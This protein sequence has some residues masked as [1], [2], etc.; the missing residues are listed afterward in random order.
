MIEALLGFL[1]E[2]F[3][4]TYSG[5][6][7]VTFFVSMLPIVELRGAIPI[8]AALGLPPLT[9]FFV[10]IVGNML[11]V[12]VIILFVRKI[13]GWMRKKSARLGRLADRFE[14]KAKSRGA[15][16][17]RGEL[18]GLMLFVAIPLPGTGAWTGALI[19]ALLDIRLKAALPV[20]LAGVIFAG[21]IITG[22]TYG[23]VSLVA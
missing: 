7:A 22:I 21:L 14:Q 11:P 10:S 19:A 3:G 13:F 9:S 16:L 1:E 12:P 23:L 6:V 4:S 20:I 8:G 2:I 5:R 18:V 17:Y 15:R